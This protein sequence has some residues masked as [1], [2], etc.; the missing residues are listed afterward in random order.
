MSYQIEYSDDRVSAWGGFT[1]MKQFN[2]KL[3][4]REV[5]NRLAIPISTSN[6]SYDS[7]TIIESFLLS[8]WLGCYKFKHTQVMRLDDTLQQIFEWKKIPSDTTYK[9]FFQKFDQG[10]N[11]AVFPALQQWFFDQLLF[12]N[13][14]LDLDSTTI[15][16]YGDQQGNHIGYN[17]QKRNRP[18]H[19]PLFAF[20]GN[21]RMVVNSWLRSGDTS[22]AHQCIDFL[23][24]TLSVLQNKRIGLLRAD[25]GFCSDRIF[26]HL[27]NQSIS[28]VIA[29][30]MHQGVQVKIKELKAWTALGS[31]I[32]INEMDYKAS[33]WE[34]SRRVIVIRQSIN[35]RPKATG[36]KLKL[37]EDKEYYEQ[38]R[39]HIFYTNQLLPA[40]QIWEQY[41]GR[42]DCE[43]RI[44]ELKY[45]F[46]LEGFNMKDF[47]ATEAALRFVNLAYNIISLFRQVSSE[48]PEHQRLQTLRINCYAVGAWMTKRGNSRVLKMAVPIKKRKWM[49]GIF[50]KI[51]EVDFPLSLKR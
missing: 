46:A 38:Y 26:S 15:T 33:K 2:D 1:T 44:K 25:S 6:N 48:K 9:R 23:D 51:S 37:F 13:Y 41:K 5:F 40:A 42:G 4:L 8:V 16:R 11:N 45:D 31:G 34:K 30:R 36:K 39:Y 17:A 3:G 49:D 50:A 27:E 28:Y 35:I 10:I 21:E 43:N 24:E 47:F 12:D 29:G 20:L 22:S 7:S 14:A 19:H 32:W 18:S